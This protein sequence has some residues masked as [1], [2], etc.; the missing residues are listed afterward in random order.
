MQHVHTSHNEALFAAFAQSDRVANGAD[1]DLR[2][3]AVV[4]SLRPYE[5]NSNEYQLIYTSPIQLELK[6][7]Y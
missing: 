6:R 1:V 4:V 5:V 7:I 2:N 3:V